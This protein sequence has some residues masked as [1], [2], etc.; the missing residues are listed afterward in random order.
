[1]PFLP[2]SFRIS[3]LFLW[4]NSG[5]LCSKS[6]GRNCHQLPPI[7]LK[8]TGWLKG[9]I[10]N[11]KT[12]KSIGQ[13]RQIKMGRLVHAFCISVQLS[14]KCRYQPFTFFKTYAQNSRSISIDMLESKR[15]SATIFI[16]RRRYAS[17]AAIVAIQKSNTARSKKVN[18]KRQPCNFHADYWL[19]SPF[20]GKSPSSRS[21][22]QLKTRLGIYWPFW[23]LRNGRQCYVLTKPPPT[24][25]S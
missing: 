11:M 7:I 6:C 13:L 23:T 21:L 25:P 1:M 18:K 8:L 24:T 14:Y 4:G 12:F 5:H 10:E 16:E 17:Y 20:H 3:I 2:L 22:W 19:S 9:L 15:S